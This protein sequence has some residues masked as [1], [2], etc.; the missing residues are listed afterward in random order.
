MGSGR[1][2]DISS[3]GLKFAADRPLL[4]GQR[5]EVY[6]DWPVMLDGGVR[7]Q[8]VVWGEVIRTDGTEVALQIQKHDFRT[9]RVEMRQAKELAG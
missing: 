4:V 8:L 9:R 3:S 6:I 7:L 5:I 1:T 2:I